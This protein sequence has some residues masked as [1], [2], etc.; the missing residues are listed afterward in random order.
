MA[1]AGRLLGLALNGLWL[2]PARGQVIPA[3][4]L[5]VSAGTLSIAG[6]SSPIPPQ[7]IPLRGGPASSDFI[8]DGWLHLPK[9]QLASGR[10]LEVVQEDPNVARFDPE[11]GGVQLALTLKIVDA[12]G[13]SV[14]IP[15]TLTT[16]NTPFCPSGSTGNHDFCSG[17]PRNAGSGAVRFVSTVSVPAGSG[18]QAAGEAVLLEIFAVLPVA[19]ADADGAEDF[20]DDCPQT[21]DPGQSDADGDGRGDACDNCPADANFAQDDSDGD[22]LG[23][24]CDDLRIKFQPSGSRTPAG[25]LSDTGAPFTR[26][27]RYGWS[28]ATPTLNRGTL[29]PARDSLAVATTTRAWEVELRPGAYSL[30]G[31]S[32]D[33]ASARGPMN[34]TAAGIPI[35]KDASTAPGEFLPLSADVAAPDGALKLEVGG[36]AGETVLNWVGLRRLAD[37]A[38]RRSLLAVSFH[39]P[40][41]QTSPGF[42][43]D[44]GKLFSPGDR[45]WWDSAPT[46][47]SRGTGPRAVLDGGAVATSPRTWSTEVRDG[48]YDV[49]VSVGD[50]AFASGPHRV[51]I[52]GIR[53]V[54]DESTQAGEFLERSARVRVRDGRLSVTIGGSPGETEI[55][56]AAV[57]AAPDDLDDDGVPNATDNCPLVANADQTNSD[58]DALGDACDNCDTVANPGQEDTDGDGLGNVCDPLRINFQPCAAPVPGGYSKDCGEIFTEVRGYG[59]NLPVDSRDRN[60]DSDQRLDTFVLSGPVRIWEATVPNGDY[61]VLLVVGDPTFSQGPQRVVVEGTTL[62]NDE[63][64]AAGAHLQRAGLVKVRDGR[65]T[66]EIGGTAGTTTLDYLEAVSST[67]Q[68]SFLASINFQP[69]ASVTPLGWSPDSGAVYASPRNYGWSAAVETRERN[70][71]PIQLLDTLAFT[72]TLRSWEIAVPNGFYD[73]LL[74]Y[75]DPASSQGPQKILVEG[76]PGVNGVTTAAGESRTLRVPVRVVD[77]RLTLAVGGTSG[78]TA[79]QFVTV[80]SA[81]PDLDGDGAPNQTDNCPFAANAGQE[82]PDGDG[83]GSACDSCP[84]AA[85]PG[86]EDLDGDGVGDPCDPDRDGDGVPDATDVCPGVPDP[87]QANSDGDALGNACDACPNDSG[88]DADGDTIC[89]DLDN[90]PAVANTGQANLDGDAQGDACDPDDDNDGVA[91]GSDNCPTVPN[92]SQANRDGDSLGNACDPLRINFQPCASPVPAGYEKECGAVFTEVAGRGWT[93][94][95]PSRDRNVDSDQR[96][97]TFVYTSAQQTLRGPSPERRL[98]RDRRHRRRGGAAGAAAVFRGGD[99]F[100]RQRDDRHGAASFRHAPREG[101]RRPTEPGRGRPGGKHRRGLPGSL[102]RRDP[103]GHGGP[104]RLPALRLGPSAADGSR[105]PSAAWSRLRGRPARNGTAPSSPASGPN[106]RSRFST[107]S[108]PP[109]WSGPGSGTFPTASTGSRLASGIHR[110]RRVGTR[111]SWKG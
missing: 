83:L 49:T 87:G 84:G 58:S 13:G 22:G 94:A 54:D 102:R 89:G 42:L 74:A 62:V 107:P 29:E 17:T 46:M 38:Q 80:A 1:A 34:L 24:V 18:S 15:V 5:D 79:V 78:N 67:V 14:E 37:P 2:D 93:A 23:D 28:E 55:N 61:D 100:L 6:R 81:D 53:V 52:E 73:V 56:L 108:S 47:V 8:L 30:S 43:A 32:G 98:L 85:N 101:A 44:T 92:P 4:R 75:G 86:Q 51:E 91:D 11:T 45:Y 35:L 68:P 103:A 71:S 76:Q 9:L 111:W 66:V 106:H 21:A 96:L 77:G 40:A 26:T 88:N 70:L 60:L 16:D 19:D 95:L 72:G 104:G 12:A 64:T 57:I 90:C 82:D 48:Y 7:S 39:P 105:T 69:A 36:G 109:A 27:R 33:Y 3:G 31:E 41:A 97:D 110:S 50:A 25:Y 10:I 63:T 20:L 99:F 65:L 59:W